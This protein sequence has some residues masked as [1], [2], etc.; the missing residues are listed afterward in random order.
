[1]KNLG[2][3]TTFALAAI[4]GAGCNE[5]K[6]G[7]Y[8]NVSFTPSNCG[9]T[10]AGCDF[11]DSLGVG[12]L[13]NIQIAG[14]EGFSTVGVVLASDDLSVL[15]LSPVAD[16]GGRPTWTAVGIS[17]GVAR[18][19]ALQD[20]IEV[21]FVEIGVQQV[22]AI[23]LDNFV[24][25]AEGPTSD[26]DFDEIWQV[27]ADVNTSFYVLPLIGDGVPTM[28]RYT[29]EATL[30]SGLAQGL[31]EGGDLENGYLYFNVPEGDYTISFVNDYDPNL[32]LDVLIQASPA[33]M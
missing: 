26:A 24:G 28:G 8:G 12:G 10:G 13:I 3:L 4:A 7:A 33:P 31:V 14:L 25:S 18:V 19:A 17:P 15:E 32:S 6:T 2:L 11:E 20:G 21:D 27:T 23:G 5:S 1:M 29:Y 9:R 16:V 22:T 30:D